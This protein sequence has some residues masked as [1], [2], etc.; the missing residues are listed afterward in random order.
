MVRHAIEDMRPLADAR[1]HKIFYDPPAESLLMIG[2]PGRLNSVMS[3]LLSN[4]IKFTDPGGEI[5]VEVTW[6]DDQVQVAV[7]DNGPGIPEDEIP[8]V[9]EHLFRGRVTVKDPNNPI[10]GTGLGL[11]LAKTVIEQHGGQLSVVSK[12]GEGTTFSFTVPREPN[13]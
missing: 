4:A 3:N 5:H 1:K 2:D 6:D 10:D 11:A 9:F 7:S 12:V 13:S 8:R